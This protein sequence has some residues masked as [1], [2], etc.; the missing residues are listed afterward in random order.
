MTTE[1]KPRASRRK[2]IEPDLKEIAAEVE[3][4]ESAKPEPPD[5]VVVVKHRQEDGSV[6][7][8]IQVL[9]NVEVTEVQTLLELAVRGWREQIGLAS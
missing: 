4:Q 7:T 5:A 8:A 9:G 6:Q 2:K 1:Q 3:A